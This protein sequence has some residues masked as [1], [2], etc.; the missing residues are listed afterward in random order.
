[1][2]KLHDA[3]N[4][5]LRRAALAVPLIERIYRQR[6]DAL[7]DNAALRCEAARLGEELRRIRR[8]LEALTA[9]DALRD[10]AVLR[11]E[12]ARLGEALRRIRGDLDALTVECD[13]IMAERHV[14]RADTPRHIANHHRNSVIAQ[15]CAQRSPVFAIIG[16][17]GRTATQWLADAFN[18]HEGVFFAHGPNLQPRKGLLPE[19]RESE[20]FR[21][22]EEMDTFSF[23][24]VDSYFDVL[25]NLGAYHVYGN[26]HGVEPVTAYLQPAGFR[27]QYFTCAVVRNPVRR[28][29]S[30]VE[31]FRYEISVT[32]RR[33]NFYVNKYRRMNRDRLAKLGRDYGRGGFSDDDLLYIQAADTTLRYDKTYLDTGMPIYTTEQLVSDVDHFLGLFL[34]ATA[35]SVP[36]TDDFALKV[37]RLSV[38]DAR[39]NSQQ[40]ARS[41]FGSWESWI[42]A[43]F[44]NR[45]EKFGL[46]SSYEMLGYDLSFVIKGPVD[47]AAAANVRSRE[48]DSDRACSMMPWALTF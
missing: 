36:I 44:R 19:E 14:F 13:G 41:L 34:K 42:R 21:I 24:D 32:D 9:D 45:L 29:Q 16:S 28:I 25:E 1:M 38:V 47:R 3:V 11:S 20:F 48:R 37:R 26:I 17:P 31:R 22:I 8:D 40:T 7:R 6:N 18:L 2:K 23:Q 35:G 43:Y 27:R 15:K 33:R 39:G 10:S 4:A 30:F 46:R 5:A 12:T